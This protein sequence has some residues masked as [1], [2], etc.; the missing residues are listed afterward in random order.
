[1]KQWRQKAKEN[2]IAMAARR[3]IEGNGADYVLD[4]T[5]FEGPTWFL[6]LA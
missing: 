3:E 5:H 6:P 4:F 2:T 1:M